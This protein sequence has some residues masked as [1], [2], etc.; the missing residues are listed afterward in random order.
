M[1]S[2][3]PVVTPAWVSVHFIFPSNSA[4]TTITH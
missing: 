1:R 3:L 4:P 2:L